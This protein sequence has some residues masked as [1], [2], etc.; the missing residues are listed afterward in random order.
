MVPEI[1][2]LEGTPE[3]PVLMV[4]TRL[5]TWCTISARQDRHPTRPV[6]GASW[7]VAA[8][9]VGIAWFSEMPGRQAS[10]PDRE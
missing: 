9:G 5:S 6:N 3:R 7:R 4:G 1:L 8:R 2:A 10:F